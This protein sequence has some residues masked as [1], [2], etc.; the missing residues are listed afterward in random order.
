MKM[1]VKVLLPAIVM[2]SAVFA[3]RMIMQSRP[4]TSMRP[5]QIS[6]PAVDATVL[7]V[8]NYPVVIRSQGTVQPTV[9]NTLVSEVSGTV[10]GL[11]GGYVVGAAFSAGDVL[12]QLD[13]RDYAIA[14]TQAQATMAQNDAQLEEQK[15]L[16]DLA[17][18][19]WKSLG[20]RGQPSALTLRKPQLAASMANQASA[21]A[22]I[23]KAELDLQRTRIVAPYD[24]R[25]LERNIDIG[26]F[27]NRGTPVG[28]IHAVQSVDVRL[29]LSSRQLTWL[30]LPSANSPGLTGPGIAGKNLI[31]QALSPLPDVELNAVV[32]GRQHRWTGKLI[33]AEGV[34]AD[35]QQLNV[36]ARIEQP[37]ADADAPLRVGQYVNALIAGQLLEDVFVIPRSAIRENDEVLILDADQ[38]LFRRKITIAWSDEQ[39]AAVSAGLEVEE[40]LVLTPLSTVADGTPVRATIDGVAPTPLE[41]P[42]NETGKSQRLGDGKGSGQTT[43]SGS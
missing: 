32:G 16:A 22:Q 26:Q 38:R 43:Q 31:T 40:V 17:L 35:T 2:A 24:G 28:R 15:A 7:K 21:R 1:F 39:F 23:Q 25:V 30:E 33:R 11:S 6:L 20:R 42:G 13:E 9:A 19:D 8:S 5:Q 4:E 10:T 37:L 18:S 3:G 12:V 14:L 29:P 34:D 36:I 41:G 27:V